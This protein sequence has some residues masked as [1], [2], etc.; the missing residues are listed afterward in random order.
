MFV[1]VV[2]SSSSSYCANS[3]KKH[4]GDCAQVGLRDATLSKKGQHALHVEGAETVLL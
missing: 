2:C 4:T 1:G 3:S